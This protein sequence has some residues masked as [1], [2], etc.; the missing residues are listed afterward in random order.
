[1]SILTGLC[2]AQYEL[3][4]YDQ[5]IAWGDEAISFSRGFSGVHKYV[6][7]A[8][9][10]K[11]DIDAARRTI[12]RAILYEQPWDEGNSQQNQQILRDLNDL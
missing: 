12:S 11:G 2:R 8:Q 5:A 1:M 3:G 9:K 7:L 10:A 4:N 6:S